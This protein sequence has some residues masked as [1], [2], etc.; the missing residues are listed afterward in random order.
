MKPRDA[1]RMEAAEAMLSRAERGMALKN[2]RDALLHILSEARPD[3]VVTVDAPALP[4]ACTSSHP[5]AA[6]GWRPPI[7][8]NESVIQASMTTKPKM[9]KEEASRRLDTYIKAD[10]NKLDDYIPR[11]SASIKPAQEIMETKT[12]AKPSVA[13]ADSLWFCASSSVCSP[14][15]SGD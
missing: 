5:P 1:D 9:T 10:A 6:C 15:P 2:R 3:T 11:K 7:A 14:K 8:P 4:A 12:M 13:S